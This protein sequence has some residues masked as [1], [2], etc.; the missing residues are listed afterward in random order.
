MGKEFRDG[1]QQ[2]FLHRVGEGGKR[3]GT[4][5][6]G[7][8]SARLLTQGTRHHQTAHAVAQNDQGLGAGF[9]V[10]DIGHNSRQIFHQLVG[11][12]DITALATGQA[13]ADMVVTLHRITRTLQCKGHMVVAAHVLAQAVHQ[14]HLGFGGQFGGGPVVT[15]Q[16]VVAT[17]PVAGGGMESV[18]G[19]NG[20]HEIF[21]VDQRSIETQPWRP[22]HSATNALG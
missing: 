16:G 13:M 5:H 11:R 10:L 14:Q 7:V 8:C 21:R 9:V 6:G 12:G 2:Q 22:A 20:G 17:Q 4:Q 19:S 18:M 1:G 3:W 15:R